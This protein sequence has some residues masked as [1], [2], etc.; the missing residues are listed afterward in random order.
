[1][2]TKREI[3]SLLGRRLSSFTE[4]FIGIKV[5]C[6]DAIKRKAVKHGTKTDG[7]TAHRRKEK[8]MS[9]ITFWRGISFSYIFAPLARAF[10]SSL[11]FVRIF[12]SPLDNHH[13][14]KR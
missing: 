2:N 12:R 13:H 9:R 4:L 7:R 6:G 3:R 14:H 8:E 5:T 10:I 11:R 1:M